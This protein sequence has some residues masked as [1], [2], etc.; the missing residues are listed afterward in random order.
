[1]LNLNTDLRPIPSMPMNEQNKQNL[2]NTFHNNWSD[3]IKN[4]SEGPANSNQKF[5]VT[6]FPSDKG[7]L[8]INNQ[9]PT[10]LNKETGTSNKSVYQLV[11]DKGP[12]NFVNKQKNISIPQRKYSFKKRNSKEFKL[13][14]RG[15]FGQSSQINETQNVDILQEL[16][17][18]FQ[19]Y[20]QGRPNLDSGPRQMMQE[21]TYQ[22][23]Q[24]ANKEKQVLKNIQHNQDQIIPIQQNFLE[25]QR[26]ALYEYQGNLHQV[27]QKE[28]YQQ[29]LQP[30]YKPMLQNQIHQ[31]IP[32]EH[33]KYIM[34]F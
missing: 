27:H 25:N 15:Q 32:N 12:Q 24:N 9:Q 34:V 19:E 10:G 29:M 21:Q 31:I 5:E 11:L 22:Q 4:F 8:T 26:Q 30:E 7:Q 17:K 28:Q 18:A 14:Q 13:K 16:N 1:M 33:L 23:E 3:F 6:N 2:N 20:N